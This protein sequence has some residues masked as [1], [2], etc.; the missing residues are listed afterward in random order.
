MGDT[1]Q[2]EKSA[3]ARDARIV[4]LVGD[5][6]LP[7]F[8]RPG[9]MYVE[10]TPGDMRSPLRGRHA[11]AKC[12]SGHDPA[13]NLVRSHLRRWQH[14]DPV[15]VQPGHGSVSVTATLR[16]RTQFVSDILVGNRV[17]VS[18][19]SLASSWCGRR[20]QRAYAKCGDDPH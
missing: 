1:E 3:Q 10:G 13:K 8:D 6:T 2:R 15:Q 16:G 14:S 17:R 18:A 9:R 11:R 20:C 19:P 4:N 5:V 12:G 7:S